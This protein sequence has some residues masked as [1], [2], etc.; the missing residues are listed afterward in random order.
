MS[1]NIGFDAKRYFFNNSGLGN[2]SRSSIYLLSK[3]F[4]ED[5]HV[6]F[7]P[8]VPENVNINNSQIR[9]PKGIS[10]LSPSLWRSYAMSKDIRKS[11]VEI[12]HGLSNE[13][14]ADIKKA[15]CRSVVT[16]HDLIFVHM[17]HLY[18]PA[19]R[20]IYTHKYKRS[21]I[22]ADRIIAI[23][24]QTKD[25]LVN[26]WNINPNK[27]DIV[28]QGCSDIFYNKA[29]KEEIDNV[30]KKYSLPDEYILSVGSIEERK[31]LLLTVR[32]MAEGG[33]DIPL[34]GCGRKTPYADQIMEYAAKHGIADKIHLI[35]NVAMCDLPAIYQKASVSVYAS[36]YEGFGIPIIEALNS[37]TPTITSRGG[38]FSETGGEACLYVDS[39]DVLEMTEALR[40][41]LE[42][43][44]V[45]ETMIAKGYEY[46]KRF[47]DESVAT[48]LHNV[49]EKLL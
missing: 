1:I 47:S 23:S 32:A 27:I 7:T 3:Y 31:N 15:G 20:I 19:D 4:S 39:S 45:R 14:P 48:S 21:C 26:I 29:S 30:T 33:I 37:G 22:N 44:E 18:K 6:L 40:L 25:D 9:I 16:L 35:H 13:L 36:K 10:L 34:V 38:V 49:Y 28:Y 42:D 17:P 24:K 2:Y 43:S 41:S 5:N 12:Y 46:V 8:K 11:G